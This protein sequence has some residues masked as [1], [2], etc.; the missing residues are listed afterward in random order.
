M[1][2]NAQ[3]SSL[4]HVKAQQRQAAEMAEIRYKTGHKGGN[5]ESGND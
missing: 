5:R 1:R 4:Q 2:K 3:E